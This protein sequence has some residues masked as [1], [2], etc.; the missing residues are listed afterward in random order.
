MH[1]AF[2]VIPRVSVPCAVHQPTPCCTIRCWS[3]AVVASGGVDGSFNGAVHLA[4]HAQLG[5]SSGTRGHS[6]YHF[7]AGGGK[8]P[9]PPGAAVLSCTRSYVVA[10]RHGTR[11]R[12]C[13]CG[14]GACAAGATWVQAGRSRVKRVDNPPVWASELPSLAVP[15]PVLL[16]NTVAG[17]RAEAMRRTLLD[18]HVHRLIGRGAGAGRVVFAQSWRGCEAHCRC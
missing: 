14:L 1:D 12:Q 7:A 6:S 13:G 11:P 9:A 4:Q 10:R 2:H 5:T 17:A 15:D 16:E 8:M 3:F 18:A